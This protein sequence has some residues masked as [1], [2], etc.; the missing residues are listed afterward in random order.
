MVSALKQTK[1][2]ATAAVARDT[3]K[4]DSKGDDETSTR[5]PTRRRLEVDQEQERKEMTW[6]EK[7][8]TMG[9]RT[10]TSSTE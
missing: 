8:S 2:E 5:L 3:M 7:V 4:D 10:V 9:N 1:A 6:E